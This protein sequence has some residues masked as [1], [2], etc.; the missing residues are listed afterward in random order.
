MNKQCPVVA[1]EWQRVQWQ[2]ALT[3][4]VFS[5]EGCMTPGDREQCAVL[6]QEYRKGAEH[7]RTIPSRTPSCVHKDYLR[8]PWFDAVRHLHFTSPEVIEVFR[9]N[10][11]LVSLVRGHACLRVAWG[12]LRKV[13]VKR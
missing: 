10:G 2:A 7:E 8:Q 13:A 1:N 9:S 12:S 4:P 3:D 6:A 5:R 11:D